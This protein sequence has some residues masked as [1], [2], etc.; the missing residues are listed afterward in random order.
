MG[1][2]QVTESLLLAAMGPV[3]ARIGGV[4]DLMTVAEEELALASQPPLFHVLVPPS[5]MVGL[6]PG[7]YRAHCRELIERYRTGYDLTWGTDA[8]AL[9]A[10]SE[11][12]LRAP[13]NSGR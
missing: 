9:C 11:M 5:N 8:E 13:L 3:G 12:S 1:S 4:F 10:L 2:A 7:V 6:A